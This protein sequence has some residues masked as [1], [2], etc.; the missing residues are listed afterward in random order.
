[1]KAGPQ[2]KM[3]LAAKFAKERKD[4]SCHIMYHKD[5]MF[6]RKLTF[7]IPK[8][9]FQNALKQKISNI[10]AFFRQTGLWE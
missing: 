2:M 1:M 7:E 9:K 6:K 4:T 5:Q 3:E 10:L 8:C